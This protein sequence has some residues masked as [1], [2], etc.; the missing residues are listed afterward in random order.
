MAGEETTNQGNIRPE[1]NTANTGLNLDLTVNQI[2]KGTLT[3]ALNA[4]LENF[5]ASSVN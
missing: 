1:F 3:Y 5:D 2:P 4:S